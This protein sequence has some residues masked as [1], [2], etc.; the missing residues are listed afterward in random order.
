MPAVAAAWRVIGYAGA[1]REGEQTPL[2]AA[3]VVLSFIGVF[4]FFAA[5]LRLISRAREG[6]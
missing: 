5:L 3:T 1:T 2:L 4:A 6:S